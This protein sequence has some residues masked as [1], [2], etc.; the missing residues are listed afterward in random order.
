MGPD[1]KN[2]HGKMAGE[3]YMAMF[4]N[5]GNR[6]KT[7]DALYNNEELF[8][9]AFEHA[10]TGMALTGI[11]GRF[12]KVNPYLCT[13]LGYFENELLAT[14][15]EA[16][17]HPDDLLTSNELLQQ[18]L[19]SEVST[20][21][22]EKRY[23]HK[24]GHT[25]WAFLSVSMVRD[26]D[27]NPLH[28][29]SHIKDITEHKKAVKA[30]RGSEE[31]YRALFEQAPDSILLFDADTGEL[32]EFNSKTHEN[33]GYTS[34]EF[35]KLKIQDFEVFESE[36]EVNRHIRK[37]IGEGS[38][39]FETKHRTKDGRIRDILARSRA[40]SI[41]GRNFILSILTDISDRKMAEEQI[42]AALEDNELLL[43]EIHH[44]VK[45]NLQIICS[46]FNLQKESIKDK[47][48]FEMVSECQNRIRAIALV[49]EK[50][51]KSKSFAYINIDE[52]IT[53]LIK[54][55][56]SFYEI[57]P[58]KIILKVDMDDILL[59][60][61]TAIPVGLIIT[62]LTSNSLQYAFPGGREGEINITVR[63]IDADEINIVI[64]DN[65]VGL[66]ANVNFRNAE[67]LGLQIVDT[68]IKQL[69]GKIKIYR[70]GGTRFNIKF[71]LKK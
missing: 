17:T 70:K 16:I 33:L 5:A 43:N 68:L 63:L 41:G 7:I 23:I 54:R 26:K 24:H 46:L 13:M 45:N 20:C 67:S 32:A 53:D 3:E 69:K 52:Y 2:S 9:I 57:N 29:I 27:G 36:E 49:H 58:N 11:D 21:Q 25:V 56:F 42:K 62:E 1:T 4:E 28:F 55:L 60:I 18:M 31:K 59:G 47:E 8:Q 51:Y 10:L 22:I 71:R 15:F 40:V 37:I 6:E 34:E 64:S 19:A 66:P 12:L 50:L 61:N 48:T 65:G 38:D 30:L 35:K 39:I 44:R 14:T